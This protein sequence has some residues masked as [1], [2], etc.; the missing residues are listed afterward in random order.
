MNSQGTL[1]VNASYKDL[2]SNQLN[3]REDSFIFPKIDDMDK[4][5]NSL[6]TRSIALLMKNIDDNELVKY[7]VEI[8]S[9][10]SERSSRIPLVRISAETSSIWKVVGD[11]SSLEKAVVILNDLYS[12][13]N[14]HSNGIYKLPKK[15]II[16]K[17]STFVSKNSDYTNFVKSIADTNNI[18]IISFDFLK[19]IIKSNDKINFDKF[20]GNSF[21]RVIL[22]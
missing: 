9:N 4:M 14:D 5:E 3:I 22:N 7:G 16:L 19:G 8:K 2:F 17:D 11:L 21:K 18:T 20:L 13:L 12:F 15:V 6:F 1:I 10:G